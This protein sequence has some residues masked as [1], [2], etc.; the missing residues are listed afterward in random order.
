MLV[1]PGMTMLD[2]VGPQYFLASMMGAQVHLVSKDDRKVPVMGDTGFA[3]VPTSSF[4]TCP[5]QLDVL[6]VPGGTRGT[7]DAMGD[8][9]TLD[10]LTH[11]ARTARYIVSVC[12]GA[13]LL[14]QAGL[15]EGKRATTHWSVHHLLPRFG[16]KAVRARH[17]H[18][19]RVFTGAG[20]SAGLDLA[21]ALLVELRGV[22][23][24]KVIQL[25]AEY[26]PE[27]S[28]DA[29]TPEALGAELGRPLHEAFA[30]AIV[31]FERIASERRSRGLAA[32]SRPP[33]SQ[34]AP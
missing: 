29:G 13:L 22:P 30:P 10:F 17:V 16:A 9:A 1:Y 18:D 14:G 32:P 7:L 24:A 23:Y 27:P 6:F 12:T 21:L 4:S 8:S 2:L 33:T 26:A 28:L 20:V 31:E 15:L 5:E 34:D 25:Q 19:G 11:R 3:V